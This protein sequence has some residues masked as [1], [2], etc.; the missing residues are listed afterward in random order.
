[1]MRFSAKQRRVL[2]WWRP[3]SPDAAF[4]A[5]ICDGAVR[6]GKTLCMGLSFFLWASACYSGARF[7]LCGKT[8]ASLRRNVVTELLPKL[9]AIGFS[10]RERRTEN[11]LQV[12]YRGHTNEFYLF[13]GRDEGSAALIQGITFAGVLLDEVARGAVPLVLHGVDR[14]RG[15]AELPV[16]P[17]YDGGQPRAVA[18][19]P[20]PL[21]AAVLRRV[22]PPLRAGPVG[23]G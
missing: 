13:G 22:L 14:P 16:P 2:T 9:Q 12:S 17:L 8:I 19:Y 20:Q 23:G 3:D 6:S 4:E 1:M 10:V 11:L 18:R 7:G 5:I 21:C 15:G